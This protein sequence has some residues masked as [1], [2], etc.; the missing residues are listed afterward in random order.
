MK[1]LN[2]SDLIYLAAGGTGG[3]VFPAIAT[4]NQLIK[5]GI[6]ICFI[7]DK[8]GSK[9][10]PSTFSRKIIFAESPFS[11]S[12]I[13]KIIK[14]LKLSF[15]FFQMFKFLINKRPVC[16]VGFGGYPSAAPILVAY[17]FRIPTLIHEQNAILGRT[18]KLL[19]NF[20][21]CIL[22]SWEKTKNLPSNV[23]NLLTGLPTRDEFIVNKK[24]SLK[25]KTQRLNL[26]ILGGTQ[27]ARIFGDFIPKSILKLP[28][29]IRKNLFV[30][31]QAREEQI[32]AIK[33]LYEINNLK[34]FIKTFFNDISKK[35]NDADL[36]VCRAG[37]SSIAEISLTKKAAILIPYNSALD[38]HQMEN[39]KL[40]G[41]IKG[42]FIINERNFTSNQLSSLINKLLT[43]SNLRRELASNANLLS[44]PNAVNLISKKI[45]SF[46]KFSH[47]VGET[48]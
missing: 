45:I 4:A 46:C 3:H 48:L 20:S 12:F 15:G 40:L 18:N 2:K 1:N 44:K 26:L 35:I 13:I 38:N 8:R 21:S 24:F 17:I 19:S 5:K 32:E 14:L 25:K 9:L 10:I 31:Q 36:I 33:N 34:Y 37:A 16:I 7:T 30:V 6:K 42:A 28:L 43:N 23:P 39:A 22:Y 47:I 41:N 27:G 29:K 11:G